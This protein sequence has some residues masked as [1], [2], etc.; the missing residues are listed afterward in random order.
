LLFVSS[1]VLA[2]TAFVTVHNRSSE[3]VSLRPISQNDRNTLL[4]ADRPLPQVLEPG[5]KAYFSVAPYITSDVNFAS[6]RYHARGRSCAF[7]TNYVNTRKGAGRAPRWNHS[8][9]GGP[10]CTS[11]IVKQDPYLHDWAVEFT[12]D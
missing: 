9:Q 6:V 8:A 10:N 7:L 2:G 1:S 11:R 5:S 4:Y 3:P 12:I